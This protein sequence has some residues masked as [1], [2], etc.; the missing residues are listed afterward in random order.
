MRRTTTIVKGLLLVLLTIGLVGCDTFEDVFENEKEA[1]GVIEALADDGSSL[2]VEAIEYRIT[3]QTEYDEGLSS[4]D[5][6]SV[7]MEVEIEYD[8]QGG[9]REALEIELVGAEDDDD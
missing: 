1:Q 6:L 5:D 2:T 4:F 3:S 9:T 8:E 7:G